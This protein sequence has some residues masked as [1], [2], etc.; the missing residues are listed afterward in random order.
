M[1]LE[2]V[3]EPEIVPVQIPE[4]VTKSYTASYFEKL[5]QFDV[6]T[7]RD[8]FQ[9]KKPSITSYSNTFHASNKAVVPMP[10]TSSMRKP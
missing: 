10:S 3:E 1:Y 4:P 6:K 5:D 9:E 7:P 8:D 2:P